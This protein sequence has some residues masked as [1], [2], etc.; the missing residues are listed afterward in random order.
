MRDIDARATRRTQQQHTMAQ[1][2]IASIHDSALV[3][4]QQCVDEGSLVAE[5]SE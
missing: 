5:S 1:G 4:R 2:E 3:G